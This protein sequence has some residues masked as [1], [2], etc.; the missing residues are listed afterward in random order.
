MQATGQNQTLKQ[1]LENYDNVF[2]RFM[3]FI[4][5][6]PLKLVISLLMIKKIRKKFL[7]LMKSMIMA[8][9]DRQTDVLPRQVQDDKYHMAA[10]ILDAMNMAFEN[11]KTK[12]HKRQV[13]KLF[14]NVMIN[15]VKVIRKY[16]KTHGSAPPGFVTISPGKFCNLKCAG[17]Y[18]N[19][20]SSASEKLDFEVFD[21]IIDQQVKLWGSSFTVISGGEPFLYESNGKTLFDIAARHPET[22]F[23]VYTNG[24]L[25]TK[26]VAVKLAKLGNVSPAISVEGYEK[27][28]D[29]RRGPGVHKKILEA[30]ENLK[31]AGVPFG[32]SI[33][34]TKNNADAAADEKLFEFYFKR[35]GAIYAWIFQYMPIGRSQTLDLMVTPE[36]RIKLY[37]TI[38]DLINNKG[39]F[40]ADFWNCG[41]LSN[42]C[43]SAGRSG[44]YIYIDWNGN[45]TPCVFNPYAFAS[46]YDTFK[47]GKTLDDLLQHPFLKDI[48]KWQDDYAL[49]KDKKEL[50]NWIL[51][52]AIKDHYKS[53]RELLDKHEVWPIDEPAAEA[54]KDEKYKTGLIKKG[55]EAAEALDP[56]WLS[57]YINR[58]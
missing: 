14:M 2:F 29:E 38:H 45:V 10:N 4:S 1:R 39:Y 50:G 43:I 54:L 26:E 52:C 23:M 12:K 53:M 31:E 33:T 25:I 9:L 35:H 36:Q 17:C 18:A 6:Y 47:E 41:A 40:I 11:A 57:D 46:I 28:T 44:G 51:P 13:I 48:R 21:K 34:T 42:G 56:I 58:E 7:D 19:A 55:E 24:T 8:M 32:I 3:E 20:D 37:R 49:V 27:E 30:M 22:F 5:S 16:K 15:R